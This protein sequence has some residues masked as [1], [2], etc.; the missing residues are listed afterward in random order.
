MDEIDYRATD[1]AFII[2]Y[3]PESGGKFLA[4]CLALSDRALFQD[5]ATANWQLNQHTTAQQRL[6]FLLDR[7]NNVTTKWNDLTM[8]PEHLLDPD[9]YDL[10][11][12]GL[13]IGNNQLPQVLTDAIQ[14]NYYLPFTAH[15]V[16]ELARSLEIFPNARVILFDDVEIFIQHRHHKT[17]EQYWNQIRGHSWPTVAP[18]S[19]DQINQLPESIKQELKEIFN[20]EIYSY[21]TKNANIIALTEF[22]VSNNI[23]FTKWSCLNYLNEDQLLIELEKLY[24]WLDLPGYNAELVKVFYRA[25]ISKV[26]ELKNKS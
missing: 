19:I 7:V 17:V 20:N 5:E 9:F 24:Q 22:L 16:K 4:N 6:N 13:P 21:F 2:A 23:P 10:V 25:W 12:S 3:T 8:G 14:K 15:T 11:K 1:T 26:Q 18:T